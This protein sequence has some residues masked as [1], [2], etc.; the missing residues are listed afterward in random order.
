MVKILVMEDYKKVLIVICLHHLNNSY[1]TIYAQT[2]SFHLS[3]P[4]LHA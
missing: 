4:L 2:S 3:E 1:P